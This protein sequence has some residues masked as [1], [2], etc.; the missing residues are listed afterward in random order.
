MNH[1]HDHLHDRGTDAL[2]RDL[3]NLEDRRCRCCG[4]PLAPPETWV[5][6]SCT[7]ETRRAKDR[8]R[9]RLV[10]HLGPG[11]AAVALA[12]AGFFAAFHQAVPAAALPEPT[13]LSPAGPHD[14][15]RGQP[16]PHQDDPWRGPLWTT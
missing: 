16:A 2:L 3:A 8:I 11:S 14:A 9:D 6:R 13:S 12:G 7:D 1:P 5:C 10:R 15:P 4:G